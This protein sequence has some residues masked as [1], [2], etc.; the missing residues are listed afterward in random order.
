[1]VLILTFLCINQ[2]EI[3]YLSFS[4]LTYHFHG[5]LELVCATPYSP[6]PVVHSVR[7]Y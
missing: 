2:G 6:P 3:K 4:F 5:G 7:G 1:M